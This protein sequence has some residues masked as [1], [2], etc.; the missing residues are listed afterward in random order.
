MQIA[1]AA[2][3]VNLIGMLGV[4]FCAVMLVAEV[5]NAFQQPNP[6]VLRFAAMPKRGAP[7]DQRLA[8]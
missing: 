1:H 6:I 2:T 8:A 5:R 4:S 7:P 3:L